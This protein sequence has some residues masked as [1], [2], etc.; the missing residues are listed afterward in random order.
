VHYALG[1]RLRIVKISETGARGWF[2]GKFPEAAIYS[3]DFELC[4][5]TWP[6][7]EIAP[8][9]HTASTEAILVI[10]GQAIVHGHEVNPG[11]MYILKAGE[12]N[13]SYFTCKTVVLGIKF[14]AGADDKVLV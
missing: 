10:S 13:D 6:Q 8:H 3:E 14:P 5:T 11:E 7:G 4:Y 2:V 9:Y 1:T 12:V